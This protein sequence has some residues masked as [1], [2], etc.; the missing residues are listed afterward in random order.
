MDGSVDR[1]EMHRRMHGRES[2]AVARM[3]CDRLVGQLL[4]EVGPP[5]PLQTR[6]IEAIEQAVDDGQ[7]HLVLMVE[8]RFGDRAHG[9]R[10]LFRA[11]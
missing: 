7:G 10:G 1:V 6:R 5:V 11:T 3:L 9:P 8:H 4:D 2:G